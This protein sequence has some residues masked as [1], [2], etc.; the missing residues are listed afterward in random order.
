MS[1]NPMEFVDQGDVQ[2]RLR[3]LR[4]GLIAAVVIIFLV[5]LLVPYVFLNTYTAQVQSAAEQAQVDNPELE[6]NIPEVGITNFLLWAIVAAVVTAV[7]G[8]IIYFV[9]ARILENTMNSSA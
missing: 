8:V 4:Y 1:E 3:L 6:F 9:Y 2:G 7:I 5:T